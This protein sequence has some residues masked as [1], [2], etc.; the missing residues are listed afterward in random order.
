MSS[1]QGESSSAR[2]Q[3]E[4]ETSFA[5]DNAL[6]RR[7]LADHPSRSYRVVQ[8][9]SA[10][11][12]L[13]G[14]GHGRIITPSMVASV[15]AAMGGQRDEFI[16]RLSAQEPHRPRNSDSGAVHP[17]PGARNVQRIADHQT[18]VSSSARAATSSTGALHSHG[19]SSTRQGLSQR[20]SGMSPDGFPSRSM[21]EG[22]VGGL[23]QRE[24]ADHARDSVASAAASSCAETASSEL[25]THPELQTGRVITILPARVDLPRRGEVD[26]F[27]LPSLD[28]IDRMDR[29]IDEAL[30]LWEDVLVEGK[31]AR[32][33]TSTGVTGQPNERGDKLLTGSRE[34]LTNAPIWAPIAPRSPVARRNGQPVP[35]SS[36]P[37]AHHH[38]QARPPLGDRADA[39]RGAEEAQQ[40]ALSPPSSELSISD[41]VFHVRR[42]T[43]PPPVRRSDLASL[44]SQRPDG[45]RWGSRSPGAAA[46]L[47]LRPSDARLGSGPGIEDVPAVLVPGGWLGIGGDNHPPARVSR[48]RGRDGPDEE[49]G[50]RDTRRRGTWEN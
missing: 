22:G 17:Q 38:T 9:D 27:L 1:T 7:P 18:A 29:Q 5:S 11:T 41:T 13:S 37:G 20:E 34:R 24:S 48:R 47:G 40:R 23:F 19:E 39:H 45:L 15:M 28:A 25:T 32:P 50:A 12:P 31:E 36:A 30:S 10:Y 3:Q 49:E 26:R 6:S 14:P 44:P 21:E 8:P 46:S 42:R 43:P 4:P 16:G 2:V 35:P 33:S